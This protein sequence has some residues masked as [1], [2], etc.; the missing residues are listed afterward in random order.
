MGIVNAPQPPSSPR[1]DQRGL[2]QVLG[3]RR[4][5]RQHMSEVQQPRQCSANELS[6]LLLADQRS[7]ALAC[8]TGPATATQVS[9][10]MVLPRLKATT[11]Y[12]PATGLTGCQE[13]RKSYAQHRQPGP[14]RL[15]RR[16]RNRLSGPSWSVICAHTLRP[17]RTYWCLRV[18]PER[19]C[20]TTTSAGDTGCLHSRPRTLRAFEFH[21]LRHTGN[22]LTAAMG[23]TLREL[24][25]RMGHSSARAALIYLHG[26]DARQ[27]E[28][29]RHLSKVAQRELQAARSG[30]QRA[31]GPSRSA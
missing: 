8:N 15:S 29:A 2:H 22:A 24:M 17:N 28:I 7:P 12:D 5:S 4:I 19:R 9:S 30:T 31:R 18:L 16:R 10:F 25:D 26:S 20:V 13:Q 14:P 11:P 23:P 1:P 6:E 21:D 3:R 27:R